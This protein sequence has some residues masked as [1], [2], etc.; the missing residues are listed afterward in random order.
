MERPK[1]D[2]DVK[3]LSGVPSVQRLSHGTM[4]TDPMLQ[5]QQWQR[6]RTEIPAILPV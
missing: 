2:G 5:T 6:P 4:P 1:A 3:V